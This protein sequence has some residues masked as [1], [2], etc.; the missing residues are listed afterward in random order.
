MGHKYSRDEILTAAVTSVLTDGLHRLTYG[1]VAREIGTSDRVVAYYFPTT[2]DLAGAVLGAMGAD[3]QAA[4]DAAVGAP[5]PDHRMLLSAAW[6]SL[7]QTD[8]DALFAVYFEA[9]GLAAAGREPYATHVPALVEA[10]V[11]WAADHLQG[12]AD[13]RRSEA[14]ATIASIDGLLLVRQLLGVEAAA[15]AAEVLV[16]PT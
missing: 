4:L 11:Q 15:R 2:A 6:P 8:H 16:G 14:E 13:R 3:L 5:V 7:A 10:W 9:A 1:R 12:S